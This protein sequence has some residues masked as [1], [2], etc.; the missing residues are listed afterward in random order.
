M[1]DSKNIDEKNIGLIGIGFI[2]GFL[3]V[4]GIS[5]ERTI[6]F[7]FFG[8]ISF[9]ELIVTIA[10]IIGLFCGITFLVLKLKNI[11]AGVGSFVSSFLGGY[12]IATA[13][14]KGM[15]I[16]LIII[17]IVAVVISFV[18]TESAFEQ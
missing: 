2:P 11:A 8:N 6:L 17:G 12:L 3:L 10:T 4:L 5:P 14:I 16:V 13:M 9:F 15:D 7:P 1:P 18:L